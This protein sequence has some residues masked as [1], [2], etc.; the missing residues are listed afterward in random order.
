MARVPESPLT[1]Q[2]RLHA[3][4]EFLG[5]SRYFRKLPK[6]WSYPVSQYLIGCILGGWDLQIV[7]Q[8][9]IG[10]RGNT[11]DAE[12]RAI[13]N[14]CV[15]RDNLCTS[16]EL[17]S[18]R[19]SMLLTDTHALNNGVKEDIV[20][21]Y[22]AAVANMCR[23][24]GWP[25]RRFSSLLD[26]NAKRQLKLIHEDLLFLES[27]WNLLS[28]ALRSRLV[29]NAQRRSALG[30]PSWSAKRYVAICECEGYFVAHTYPSTLLLSYQAPEL[31]FLLPSMPTLLA[32]V[33]AGGFKK[34][35]WY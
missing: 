7:V 30:D 23:G 19:V 2:E 11:T 31:A 24:L 33:E 13:S 32:H 21:S 17:K 18:C 26:E 1:L 8:W 34:R 3:I 12:E 5:N 10:T 4:T 28:P 25:I 14:L 6:P 35:P 15:V 9:G 29:Q 20:D 27:R 16:L 22:S